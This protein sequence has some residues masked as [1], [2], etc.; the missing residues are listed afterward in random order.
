MRDAMVPP[1]TLIIR[2]KR[3][4]V[5]AC[6]MQADVYERTLGVVPFVQRPPHLALIGAEVLKER[7][8]VAV[9]APGVHIQHD[10]LQQVS[11]VVP[12]VA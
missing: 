9:T 6:N 2:I 12:P 8:E 11:V 4:P 7:Y 5:N 3:Q 1:E 10:T